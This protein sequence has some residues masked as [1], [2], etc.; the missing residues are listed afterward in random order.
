MCRSLL[1]ELLAIAKVTKGRELTEL[2]LTPVGN[3]FDAAVSV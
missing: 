1:E 3:E 2:D